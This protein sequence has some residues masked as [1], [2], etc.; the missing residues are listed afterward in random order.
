M[1]AYSNF[2]RSRFYK[3]TYISIHIK[4]IRLEMELGDELIFFWRENSSSR[5]REGIPWIWRHAKFM[6]PMLRFPTGRSGGKIWTSLLTACWRLCSSNAKSYQ[7][8]CIYTAF[9]VKPKESQ[10]ANSWRRTS[11]Q[12]AKIWSWE[13]APQICKANRKCVS[14]NTR[15]KASCGI[16]LV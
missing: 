1:C 16:W 15:F 12:S 2:F 7:F 6:W 4:G 9:L 3:D 14:A 11:C 8:W 10:N 13:I 5:P